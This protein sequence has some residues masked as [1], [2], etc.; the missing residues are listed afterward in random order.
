MAT[1]IILWFDAR[2][3]DKNK[4]NKLHSSASLSDKSRLDHRHNNNN[5]KVIFQELFQVHRI[6]VG[7]YLKGCILQ[8]M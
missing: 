2:S 7:L 5:N 4:I 1:V 3:D 6:H 8:V